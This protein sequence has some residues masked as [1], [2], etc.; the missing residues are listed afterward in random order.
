[1][2]IVKGHRKYKYKNL[3]EVYSLDA[4][5]NAEQRGE[6]SFD[7]FY[8][9]EEAKR[10]MAKKGGEI[11]TQ[12]D[13]GMDRAYVRGWAYVNRTGMYAVVRKR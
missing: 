7:V 5:D 13:S 6:L 8:S 2:P 3:K 10:S 12:V 4:I 9:E 11:Y 1:M